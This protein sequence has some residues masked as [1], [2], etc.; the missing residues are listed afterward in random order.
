MAAYRPNRMIRLLTAVVSFGYFALC[1][2]GLVLL[3]AVAGVELFADRTAL[4]KF[5]LGTTATVR[6]DEVRLTSSWGADPVTLRPTA[7]E[8][9]VPISVAPAW[10]RAITYSSLGALY[11]LILLFAY[12][13][14]R[15]F[16]RVRDGA[17]FD[18]RNA[19]RLR[20][21]GLLLLV[22]A[23]AVGLFEFWLSV[24]II[25]TLS[26]PSVAVSPAFRVDGWAVFVALV[27]MALAEIFRRGSDLEEEQSLVV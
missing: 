24:A 26:M 9:R 5:F 4:A 18:A 8:L 14:R 6:L 17:P 21:L 12:H 23:F 7:A 10:F 22:L 11:F 19:S 15:L 2:F 27:M 13:L 3:I 20:W 25:R 16:Q 1:A